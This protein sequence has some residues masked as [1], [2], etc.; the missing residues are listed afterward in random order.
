MTVAE[1]L[2]QARAEFLGPL[3]KDASAVLS[4]PS[5]KALMDALEQRF[6]DGNLAGANDAETYMNLGAREVVRFLRG[7]RKYNERTGT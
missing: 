3:A 2:E 5:G 6:W 1:Q 7:L 4:S